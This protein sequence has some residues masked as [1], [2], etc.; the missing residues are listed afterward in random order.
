MPPINNELGHRLAGEQQTLSLP[1]RALIRNAPIT[2]HAG[3]SVGEAVAIMHA[4]G[5]GAVVVVDGGSHP[6]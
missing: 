3:Q 1:L 2:C 6:L 5:T 4:R